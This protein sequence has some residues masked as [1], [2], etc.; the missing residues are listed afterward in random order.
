MSRRIVEILFKIAANIIAQMP[1]R[2]R[3]HT[4]LKV[5]CN[6]SVCVC[7]CACVFCVCFCARCFVFAVF[8]GPDGSSGGFQVGN[9]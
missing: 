1:T 6:V 8:G 9:R 5:H 2:A 3:L 7:V 4:H